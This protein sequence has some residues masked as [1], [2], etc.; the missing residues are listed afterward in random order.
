[1]FHI[2]Y[3]NFRKLDQIETFRSIESDL[4]RDRREKLSDHLNHV[5]STVR[6]IIIIPEDPPQPS[7]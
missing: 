7:S 1:M 4:Y 2:K 6:A 3:I 5:V